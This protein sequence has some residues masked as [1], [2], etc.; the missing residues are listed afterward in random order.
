MQLVYEGP[1]PAISLN[2]GSFVTY[3]R[4]I[5]FEAEG[6]YAQHLLHKLHPHRFSVV[7]KAEA[8]EV[9][10]TPAKRV[11]RKPKEQ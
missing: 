9:L 3:T 11:G 10:A 8:P 4:G 1:E 2:I 5:P 6:G 7:E